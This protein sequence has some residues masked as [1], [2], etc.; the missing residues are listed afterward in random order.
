M[1][2][3][4]SFGFRI[5]QWFG[6]L[7]ILL[8]LTAQLPA[9]QGDEP[10]EIQTPLIPPE[11]IP[12]A[13][14]LPP[15]EALKSFKLAPGF[16]IEL[17]AAE[18]LIGDPIALAFSPDG[19]IYVLE[20][21]GFMM[22]PEGRGEDQPL[23]RVVV[24]EDSNK[25]GVMDRQTVFVDGLVMPRGLALVGDGVL[26]AEPPHVWLFRDT[27]GDGKADVREEVASDFGDQKNPEHNANSFV[28][29]LDNWIYSANHTNRFRLSKGKWE[30]AATVFRGQWGITQDDFGR[31]FYNANA[32]QLRADLVPSRYFSRN[33]FAGKLTGINFQVAHDQSVWPVRVTPGINR[34]Y[35]PGMLRNGRL[36]TFTAACAPLIYRGDAFPPEFRGNAFV[37]EPSANLVRRDIVREN[38]GLIIA[39][40]AYVQAEFLASTDERFRPVNLYTGP[41]GL[42]YVVDMYHGIIQHRIYLTSYL[43][44]QIES[45][46]LESPTGLGRIYRVAPVSWQAKPIP[47][48]SLTT[49]D[50]VQDLSH[51]NGWWRD[52]AQRLLVE[53]ADPLSI[54]PLQALATRGPSVYGRLHALWTLEG[55]DRLDPPLLLVAL[56]DAYPKLQAHAIRLAERYLVISPPNQDLLSALLRLLGNLQP[57]VQLQLALTF[58]EIQLPAAEEAMVRLARQNRGNVLIRDAILS[59]LGGRELSFLNKVLAAP[60]IPGEQAERTYYLNSLAKSLAAQRDPDKIGALLNLAGSQPAASWRQLALLDGITGVLRGASGKTAVINKPVK[61]AAKPPALDLFTR[62]ARPELQPRLEQLLSVVTWPGQSNYITAAAPAPLSAADQ[63]RFEAGKTLYAAICSACHQP[64]GLGQ[65]G[66]APPLVDSD[67]PLGS[68]GRL[69]R[70]VLQGV[71]G[72]I[73]VKGQVYELDM[74]TL[75]IL[76]DEQIAGILTYIRREWGHA[77]SPIT[78]ETVKKIRDETAQRD[79]AWTE[80][81]LLKLP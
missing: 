33:R 68:P 55:L 64:H 57:D 80:A 19:R 45:R 58:G 22:N 67:W 28:W 11:Q 24:L 25:D 50:L 1:F 35:Q 63:A 75:G 59:G 77:A 79:D 21:R 43:R 23:G 41:D 72:P 26:V 46:H 49:P 74:P 8:C 30:R 42:L 4:S 17:V 15:A 66:L 62:S 20:M 34:G 70:I 52:T 78:T 37:A 60:D 29:A 14:A 56:R 53:R 5:F 40:N 7:L 54:A 12:P 3:I 65:E 81:E 38:D 31:L 48:M 10:G 44:K 36:A 27:N 39:T 69:V 16:K 6:F 61:L 73:H 13:P 32:D 71:R 2:R 9:Q 47:K 51:T 18:P 76:D